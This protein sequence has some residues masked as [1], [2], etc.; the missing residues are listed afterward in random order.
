MELFNNYMYYQNAL[1]PELCQKIIHYGKQKLEFNKNQG[2]NTSAHTANSREKQSVKNGIPLNEKSFGNYIAEGKDISNTYVR[3]SEIVWL[4]DQWIY[5]ELIPYAKRAN[6]NAGWNYDIETAEDIQFTVY[7][8]PGGFYGWH[9][10]GGSDW[11][12]TYRK[13]LPGI[14]PKPDRVDRL[15]AG[16]TRRINQIGLIRKVSM[17]VN[18]NVEG[19]YEGGNLKFDWGRHSTSNTQYYECT[20]IRPQ[21]SIIVFPS[22][23]Y[24]CVTP[25]TKGTRYSLVIWFLGKAFK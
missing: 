18:L 2:L 24:H 19:D 6:K 4:N 5:D 12:S 16:Y 14:S 21:G 1:S 25:V 15:P 9:R 7:N 3:D 17:T 13:Y 22:Y 10:D 20:E 23:Q 8:S 11:H